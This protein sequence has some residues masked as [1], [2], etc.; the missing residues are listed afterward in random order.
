MR[1]AQLA[2]RDEEEGNES[3]KIGQLARRA[4]VSVD[5]IRFYERRGILPRAERRPSGYRVYHRADVD[6]VRLTKALQKLGFTLDEVIRALAAFDTGSA[7]CASERWR[8]QTVIE[9]IDTKVDELLRLRGAV[10]QAFESCRAGHCPVLPAK[11]QDGGA[12]AARRRR[13]PVTRLSRP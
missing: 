13:R 1:Q 6:R 3:L 7:T 11:Q 12:V 5:A 9:R 2:G 8:L 10:V 4:S